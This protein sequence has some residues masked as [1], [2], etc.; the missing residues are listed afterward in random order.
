M[1]KDRDLFIHKIK[2]IY[3][4]PKEKTVIARDPLMKEV[5]IQNL[6]N[7]K[8][9]DT[10]KHI[11]LYLLNGRHLKGYSY[12]NMNTSPFLVSYIMLINKK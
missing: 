6:L 4:L 9:L 1:K 7:H 5:R 12:Q 10:S 2:E 8:I 3:K 11:K